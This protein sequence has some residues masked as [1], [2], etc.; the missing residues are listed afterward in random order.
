MDPL[1][2]CA[3]GADPG[4]EGKCDA[5]AAKPSCTA[6]EL[7]GGAKVYA[8]EDASLFYY[9]PDRVNVRRVSQL[10]RSTRRA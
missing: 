9:L 10:T 5:P 8:I 4:A 2:G 1:T 6:T 7:G 3:G